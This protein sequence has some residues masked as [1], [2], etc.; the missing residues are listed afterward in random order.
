MLAV[1]ARSDL[2]DAY[3]LL[4]AH[5]IGSGVS[6]TDLSQGIVRREIFYD[7]A[8]REWSVNGVMDP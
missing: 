5:A 6:M 8:T 7:Y 1:Q 2:G 3:V 4:R